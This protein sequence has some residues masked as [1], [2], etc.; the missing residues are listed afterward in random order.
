[1]GATDPPGA[2]ETLPD[3]DALGAG[4][5][6]AVGVSVGEADGEMA[7]EGVAVG[8]ALADAVAGADMDGAAFA[9]GDVLGAD[10]AGAEV[11]GE[12]AGLDAACPECIPGAWCAEAARAMPPAADAATSPTTIEAIVSGRASRR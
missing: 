2:G 9:A 11:A 5:E 12:M 7:A 4:D 1:V 6:L 3:G 8:V 10:V